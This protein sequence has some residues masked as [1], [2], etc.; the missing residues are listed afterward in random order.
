MGLPVPA[1]MDGR[2]LA[3]AF[4]DGYL[5]SFPLQIADAAAS[6]LAQA[7]VDY[8]A[9]GEQEIMERLRGLGYMG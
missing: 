5:D 1:D 2:V 6:D 3:D 9:E 8:T 4:A 7:G